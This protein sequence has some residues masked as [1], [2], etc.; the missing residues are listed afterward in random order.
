ME[1]SIGTTEAMSNHD[2]SVS[3][4]DLIPTGCIVGIL[5]SDAMS[6]CHVATFPQTTNNLMKYVSLKDEYILLIPCDKCLPRIRVCTK[7]KEKLQGK[8]LLVRLD[9]WPADSQYP[10]GHIVQ[11]LGDSYD[12]KAEMMSLLL[13]YDVYARPFSVSALMCLPSVSNA[14]SYT[15]L[16]EEA[17]EPPWSIPI[18][19]QKVWVDSHWSIPPHMLKGR[20]DLRENRSI[21]RYLILLFLHVLTFGQC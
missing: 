2:S 12:F 19:T 5:R 8:K 11:I 17:S 3:Q 4:D 18:P 14:V 1:E 20:K 7:Q 13:E 21:F 9:D 10:N 15:I 16:E 6:K